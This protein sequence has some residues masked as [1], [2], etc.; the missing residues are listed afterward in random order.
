MRILFI[1]TA[2]SVSDLMLAF[3]EL[4]HDVSYIP[5]FQV[6]PVAPCENDYSTIKAAIENVV[7]DCLVS[8]MFIP[9]V[10]EISHHYGI[11][12]ISWTYDSPLTSLFTPEIKNDNNYV[13]IFDKSECARL[14]AA[15]SANIYYL[16]LGAYVTR[17]GSIDITDEDIAKY[18]ADISFVGTLYRENPYNLYSPYLD[19]QTGQEMNRYLIA[20]SSR[21]SLPKPWPR[22]SD[23]SVSSMKS[24]FE[25]MIANSTL[26][27]DNEYLAIMF[28]SKK[29]AEIDRITCLNALATHHSVS[30]YT[31]DA[32][33]PALSG[34]VHCHGRVNYETEMSKVFYSS[35][36]NLNITLP[37]IESGIPQRIY[38][39]MACGGFCLSNYQ[40]EMDELFTIGRDIEAFRSVEELLD[41]TDYYL[42]HEDKR[43]RIA[44]NG[45]KLIKEKH[46][47]QHRVNEMLQIV[48]LTK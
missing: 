44:I 33:H 48:S 1:P 25:S 16:P 39:I 3:A 31:N 8:Y 24:T 45:Y 18:S 27:N 4:G 34:N 47:I 6:N 12:Y 2:D 20:N 15:V 30:L 38:D 23:S 41:K 14:K 32:S 9:I 37:S 13:F 46:T 21:W 29:L 10:S 11:P 42:K 22:L 43:L 36:V 28:L 19:E 7:P 35:K 5:D 17:I 26:M 40:T